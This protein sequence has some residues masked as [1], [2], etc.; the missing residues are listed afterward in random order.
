[1]KMLLV[2]PED[3][4]GA[5][6]WTETNWN[7]IVDL[8]WSGRHS[9]SLLAKRF[10]CRVLGIYDL[11][12]HEQ[13]RCQLRELLVV[14]LDQLVDSESID[15]W[16]AFSC[17][18]Y[19]QLEQFMLFSILADQVPEHAEILATRPHSAT[20]ALSILLKREVKCFLPERQNEVG[21]AARRYTKKAIALQPSQ[22]IEIAFDK[23][24]TD[25]RFRRILSHRRPILTT[26]VVLLPSAYVNVSRAQLA[27]AQMLPHRQFLLVVTRRSGRR[28]KLPANVE[29]RSLAAYAPRRSTSTESEGI[30]LLGSWQELLDKRFVANRVLGLATKLGVLK[31]FGRF[32]MS[33]LRVRDAWREVIAKE[34][35]TAVLSGDEHN[36]FTRLPIELARARNIL[37]VFCDH[38]ALNMSFG[39]RRACSDIYLAAGDMA[40]DYM[41]EWCGLATHKIVVGGPQKAQDP[42]PSRRENARDRIVFFSE[43]YELSSGRTHTLYSEMLP[44]LCSLARESDRKVIVKLHPFESY[45][46]RR[47]MIDKI[48]SA[49]EKD[50][51]EIREGPMT[52]DLFERAWFSITVE[53]SVAVES[54]TNGVPCFLCAWFDGSWYDYAKQYAKYSAGYPLNSPQEVRQIPRLLGRVKIT[55]AIRR[56]LE[57]SISPEHLESVLF[58][59]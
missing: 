23:W 18:V 53:S 11:L 19:Q 46:M 35:I 54:T 5:G 47:A 42:L 2:H 49:K 3:S 21:V 30:R 29:L 24:D 16:D 4:V 55:D 58:G 48:L 13:H 9:Y 10:G 45:R 28:L 36:A 7:L 17:S 8:G 22:L 6:P 52:P 12:D 26:P 1:M 32:L 14:G 37:T 38:G 57:T 31:E 44:E 27:Y 25:Y 59:M 56:S 39:I 40:R 33:G 50:L 51:I 15:W 34:P 41:V 43:A 20:R